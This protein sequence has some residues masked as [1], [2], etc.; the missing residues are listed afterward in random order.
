MKKPILYIIVLLLCWL[1]SG[2]SVQSALSAKAAKAVKAAKAPDSLDVE[3]IDKLYVTEPQRAYRL[4]G[5]AYD[6]LQ[7]EGW[8]TT[9]RL[10]YERVAGYVCLANHYYAKAMRHALNIE[11]MSE[12]DKN[13]LTQLSYLELQCNILDVLGQYEQLTRNLT[14]IREIA[15]DLDDDDVK[16]RST[17]CFFLL[18]CDY[19]KIRALSNSSDVKGALRE[20]ANARSLVAKYQHDPEAVVR[21]NCAIMRH[22]LDELQGE[23]YVKH[24]MCEKAINYLKEVIMELDREERRG[25]DEA[26]DKAGY[27]IHRITV[28]LLLGTA[29]A[30]CGRKAE[31]LDEAA[32]VYQLWKIYPPT[33]GTLGDLLGIYLK[34]DAVPPAELTDAAEAFYAQNRNLPSIELG[35][36]CT[37][38]LWLYIR[39]GKHA[40]AEQ[41]LKEQQRIFDYINRE[42]MEFYDV[43]SENSNL[44]ISYY[45]QRVHKVVAAG[46]AVALIIVIIGMMAYRHQRMRDS[47]YIYKYVKLAASRNEPKPVSKSRRAEQNLVDRIREVLAKDKAFLN[48]DVDY[49]LLERALLLKRRTIISKLK[50]NYQTSVKDIITDMRLEY[51]CKLLEETDYVLEY[52]ATEASFGASRTFYRAFKNKYNLTPTEYRKLSTKKEG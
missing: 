34:A 31:A 1:S 17:K 2:L 13:G 20:M 5:L 4:L 23:I 35:T 49:E 19:F 32:K 36:V 7:R 8:K 6:R 11:N 14:K 15:T 43:L 18:Y 9:T 33:S 28:R 41:M 50:E 16:V 38:L 51:A 52:I 46:V 21:G 48:P 37:D 24:G 22:S 27:D 39:E 12:D 40:Q 10:R 45:Q 42:N 29:M 44:R 25:G 3:F 30:D 47:K 26:T